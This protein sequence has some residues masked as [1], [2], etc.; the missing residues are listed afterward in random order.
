MTTSVESARRP[1]TEYRI[2]VRWHIATARKAI[3]RGDVEEARWHLGR[4]RVW[5]VNAHHWART[6]R[7]L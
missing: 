2:D 7:G 1:A 3:E 5:R 6:V 4:A